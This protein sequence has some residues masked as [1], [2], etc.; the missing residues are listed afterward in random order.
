M[1]TK[2]R[3]VYNEEQWYGDESFKSWFKGPVEK[4]CDMY[5]YIHY[6]LTLKQVAYFNTLEQA[7][8]YSKLVSICE[9][10][11]EINFGEDF[12]EFARREKNHRDGFGTFSF[13]SRKAH[14]KSVLD[15]LVNKYE[16]EYIRFLF[17][18]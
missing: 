12:L 11:K 8:E 7:E 3:V 10:I 13:D 2:F 4:R 5:G 17:S 14:K 9:D 6:V 1:K 15:K 16:K 18:N